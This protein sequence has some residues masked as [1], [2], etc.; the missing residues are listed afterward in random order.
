M[1]NI[2]AAILCSTLPL[3]SACDPYE[4]SQALLVGVVQCKSQFDSSFNTIAS[5]ASSLD[6][7]KKVELLVEAIAKRQEC[8]SDAAKR[9][10]N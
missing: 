7:Q 1:K 2:K 3:I 4:Q 10:K 8:E 6:S 9:I 5:A